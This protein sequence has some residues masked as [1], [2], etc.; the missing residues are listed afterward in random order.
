MRFQECLDELLMSGCDDWVCVAEVTSV[1]KFTGGAH[2]EDAI[3]DL[4][5]RLIRELVQRGLMEIGDPP[6]RG[7]RLAL[8]PMTPQECLDRVEREWSALGRNPSLGDLCWLQNTDKGAAL[9]EELIKK[10]AL[11]K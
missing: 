7:R 5:L 8:W 1:A 11:G 3:R 9:G 10:R 6:D 4:S 2:S